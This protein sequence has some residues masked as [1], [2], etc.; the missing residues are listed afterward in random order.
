M[1]SNTLRPCISVGPVELLRMLAFR[2]RANSKRLFRALVCTKVR[3]FK[4]SI[5][6]PLTTPS[7]SWKLSEA[8]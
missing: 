2:L 4:R 5:L 7:R 8:L 3:A 1:A 6:V